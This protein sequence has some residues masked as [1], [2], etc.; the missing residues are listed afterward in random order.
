MDNSLQRI[1]APPRR[2]HQA[3]DN[4]QREQA[5][6]KP[7]SQSRIPRFGRTI[8]GSVW[9]FMY[10]A[11]GMLAWP[12]SGFHVHDAVLVPDGD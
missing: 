6:P 1:H 10:D 3:S 12:H 2:W 11:E 8:G 4:Q 7:A 5:N 9:R